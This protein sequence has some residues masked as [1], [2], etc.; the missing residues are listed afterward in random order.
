M[1]MWHSVEEPI[2]PQELK[3][4]KKRKPRAKKSDYELDRIR[5]KKEASRAANAEQPPRVPKS[6]A[7]E[8]LHQQ[9]RNRSHRPIPVA[10]D[11]PVLSSGVAPLER[12]QA[13]RVEPLKSNALSRIQKLAAKLKGEV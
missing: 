6:E 13:P 2:D 4:P 8:S 7:E 10:P 11:K 3:N 1:A 5:E 9:M 12:P